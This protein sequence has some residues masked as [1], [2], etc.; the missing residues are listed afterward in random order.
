M[1]SPLVRNQLDD[2]AA[3]IGQDFAM[4]E[5][6]TLKLYLREWRKLARLTQQELADRLEISKTLVSDLETGKQ[7]WNVDHLS[8]LAFALGVEPDD[9]LRAPEVPP[10]LQLVWQRIP[11]SDQMQAL[12]MLDAYAKAALSRRNDE[13]A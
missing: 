13:A 10:A 2:M 1:S 7:R 9:L 4:A 3:L 6:R 5:P 8:E 12:L 11:A